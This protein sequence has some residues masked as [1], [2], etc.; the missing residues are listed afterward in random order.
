[1]QVLRETAARYGVPDPARS[2][3]ANLQAGTRYLQNLMQ[4]FDGRLDLV[5]AAYNAG[6]HAVMRHGHRIPPYQETQNYVPAVLAKYRE[7]QEPPAVPVPVSAS[8]PASLYIEYLPGTR[9]ERY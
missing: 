7:W 4:L 2:P 8:I 1:M 9:L 3:E 6:E 5:L